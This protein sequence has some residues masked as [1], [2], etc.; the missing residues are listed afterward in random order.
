MKNIDAFLL[1]KQYKAFPN[2]IVQGRRQDFAW[3]SASVGSV[4]V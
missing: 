4:G 1:T 2:V 3:M